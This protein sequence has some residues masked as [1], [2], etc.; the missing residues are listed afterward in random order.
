MAFIDSLIKAMPGV[1]KPEG[2]LPFKSRIKWTVAIVFIFLVMGQVAL[3]G[4]SESSRS[5]FQFFETI[6]GSSIGSIITLGIGP[7]ITASIILQ[8]LVGS[9]V[10]NID[11]KTSEGKAKFQGIQKITAITFCIVESIMFV[12]LGAV[13]PLMNTPI[14]VG[15]LILQLT[16]GALI[17]LFMDEVVSKW[18]IGSGISLFIAAGVTKEILVGALNPFAQSVGSSSVLSWPVISEGIYS[19]GVIPQSI[20][21]ILSQEF[22]ASVATLFPLMAT[23]IVFFFIVYIQS[24]KIEIPLAIGSVSGFARRWPLKLLY[25]STIP[26]ILIAALLANIQ[27]VSGLLANEITETGDQCGFLGCVDAQGQAVSGPVLFLQPPSDFSV[28]LI[29]IVFMIVMLFGFMAN[30]KAGRHMNEKSLLAF[31]FI[32][33]A[34][35]VAFTAFTSGLPSGTSMLRVF[36]YF[37]LITAGGTLFSMIWVSTA[38]MDSKA[39]SQQIMNT[40]MQVPGFRRDPRIMEQVLERYIPTLAIIS[41]LLIGAIAS[42]SDFTGALGSGTG[43]LLSVSIVYSLFEQMGQKYAE[44]MNPEVRKF[45]GNK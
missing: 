13:T 8:L 27:L 28:Q 24:I 19:I 36:S 15:A 25:T 31:V 10:I 3:W 20:Q 38:G 37:T 1:K 18:G 17:L 14:F 42:V 44:E 9:K 39:V 40:G 34:A 12:L 45:F 41:G 32:G 16:V 43:I 21:L 2:H 33:L 26:V 5:Q 30:L 6:L 7:I 29:F 23:V 35:G 22:F 11:T 4:I